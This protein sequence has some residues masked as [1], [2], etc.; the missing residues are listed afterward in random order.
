MKAMNRI[1]NINWSNF[2]KLG[3]VEDGKLIFEYLRRTAKFY[4]ENFIKPVP[5]IYLNVADLL[6]YNHK[7][8]LSELCSKEAVEELEKTVMIKNIV[9]SY[10]E[11]AEFADINNKVVKYLEIYEPLIRI[12]ERGGYFAFKEGGLS[13]YNAGFFPLSNWYEKF[14]GKEPIDISNI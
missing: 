9:I 13:V 4:K 8:E 11:L 3:N 14:L 7:I 1:N 10:L 5:P 12:L 2:G 6:G